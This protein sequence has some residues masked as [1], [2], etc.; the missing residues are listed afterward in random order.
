MQKHIT[1]IWHCFLRY[2]THFAP[3]LFGFPICEVKLM[4]LHTGFLVGFSSWQS[5]TWKSRISITYLVGHIKT[6]SSLYCSATSLVYRTG[7]SWLWNCHPFCCLSIH[8][9]VFRIMWG[10]FVHSWSSITCLALVWLDTGNDVACPHILI[11]AT[12]Q[13]LYR[14]HPCYCKRI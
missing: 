8:S 7:S 12:L 3:L 10:F 13:H 4:T 11:F 2:L 1:L 14:S 6:W 5:G 9:G